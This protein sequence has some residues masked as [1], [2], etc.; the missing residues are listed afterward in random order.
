MAHGIIEQYGSEAEE[1]AE[2]MFRRRLD[3]GDMRSAGVWLVIGNVIEDL[4]CLAAGK[5]VH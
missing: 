3:E 2:N 5:T 4:A 1:Y